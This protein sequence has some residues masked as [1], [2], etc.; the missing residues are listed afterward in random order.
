M[1]KDFYKGV[2]L[3]ALSYFQFIVPSRM[4]NALTVGFFWILF[5]YGIILIGD[6]ITQK[7]SHKS[8][9]RKIH[10]DPKGHWHFFLIAL[11]GGIFV[12]FV[13][14]WFGKLWI[15]PY[16]SIPIYFV[17]VVFG[18][19]LYWLMIAE[20]YLAVKSVLD[21]F[22]RTKPAARSFSWEKY[23][24][25]FLGLL[26]V[27]LLVG[28]TYLGYRDYARQGG[29]VFAINQPVY[30][31][32]RFKYVLGLFL[33]S[34][35]FLESIEYFKKRTSLIKDLMRGYF[36]PIIAIA[37]ASFLLALVM[38]TQNLPHN[39]WLY[40]NWPLPTA[41][42]LGLPVVMI[43]AWPLHYIGFLSLFRAFSRKESVDVWT[44]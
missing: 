40:T 2:I 12:E 13:A 38:E 24:Y 23:F 4:A 36:H 28:S 8:L 21:Y 11:I 16:F 10:T 31:M 35:F 25:F 34:W 42:F 44:W 33:G 32:A 39:F 37:V 43:L 1:N 5:M 20:S 29:Y 15:Y 22:I 18:F 17:C 3:F 27:I 7:L 6:G 9:I 30:V 14:Q 19:Y 26:G 41:R